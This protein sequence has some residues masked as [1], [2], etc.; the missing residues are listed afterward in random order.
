MLLASSFL[1]H[2]WLPRGFAGVCLCASAAH[3]TFHHQVSRTYIY[4]TQTCSTCLQWLLQRKNKKQKPLIHEFVCYDLTAF[5]VQP[6]QPS[7]TPGEEAAIIWELPRCRGTGATTLPGRQ[8]KLIPH[9]RT[10]VGLFVFC[11]LFFFFHMQIPDG[12]REANHFRHHLVSWPIN[13]ATVC[14]CLPREWIMW[15]T[16]RWRVTHLTPCNPRPS[17]ALLSA[18]EFHP[19]TLTLKLTSLSLPIWF[20]FPPD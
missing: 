16:Q 1:E 14:K 6:V 13:K 8:W 12:F 11:V 10:H 15:V 5:L 19:H 18:R 4:T 3:T 2:Q 7:F 9:T 20:N 17:R